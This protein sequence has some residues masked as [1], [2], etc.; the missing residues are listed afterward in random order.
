MNCEKKRMEM[1]KNVQIME[2]VKLFGDLLWVK[3]QEI[4][5]HIKIK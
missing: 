1:R 3:S 2:K 4:L 5:M